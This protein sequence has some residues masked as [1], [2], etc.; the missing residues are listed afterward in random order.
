MAVVF[1]ETR[2]TGG[3]EPAAERG[4]YVV[5]VQIEKGILRRTLPQQNPLVAMT[6]SLSLILFVALFWTLPAS[7]AV[8]AYRRHDSSVEKLKASVFGSAES[9]LNLPRTEEAKAGLDA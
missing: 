8:I 7:I 2:G 4:L 9:T 3:A 6:P 5:G 1:P